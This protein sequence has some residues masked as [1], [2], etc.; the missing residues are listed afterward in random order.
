MLQYNASRNIGKHILVQEIEPVF[1]RLSL[2][3]IKTA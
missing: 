1:H 3:F 2:Q